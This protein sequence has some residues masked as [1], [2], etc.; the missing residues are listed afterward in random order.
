MNI[1]TEIP[2]IL[3]KEMKDF[4]ESKSDFD[5]YTFLTSALNNFLYKNG[6]EDRRVAENYLNDIF[7]Q[8]PS[9]ST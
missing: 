2:E 4:I 7:D 6:C 8:S 9:E 1:E 3:F 5:Q